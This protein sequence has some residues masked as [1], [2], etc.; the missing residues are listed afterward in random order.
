M[1]IWATPIDRALNRALNLNLHRARA[2]DRALDRALTVARD[3][4]H[5]L[6]HDLG[7]AGWEDQPA[8]AEAL[9]LL[10]EA[11]DRVATDFIGADLRSA[12]LTSASLEGVR[13]SDGT[14]GEPTRWPAGCE[15]PIRAASVE[16]EPGIF[17]I[18][19]R[20]ELFDRVK[21]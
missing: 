17:Q 18:R 19:G 20:L 2:L 14:R 3:R 8:D 13:W 1:P 4:A 15:G 5:A 7:F 21:S 6:A 10:S 9:K 16:I 11:L 12:T